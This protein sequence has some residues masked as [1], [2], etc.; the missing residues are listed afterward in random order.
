M[1]GQGP[2]HTEIGALSMFAPTTNANQQ[3]HGDELLGGLAG[4]TSSL[5]IT[6]QISST[7]V[8]ASQKASKLLKNLTNELRKVFDKHAVKG[9]KPGLTLNGRL[10]SSMNLFWGDQS[11]LLNHLSQIVTRVSAVDMGAAAR[12]LDSVLGAL[13]VSNT[14]ILAIIP[15]I[16][17]EAS[18]DT[19]DTLP[20]VIPALASAMDKHINQCDNCDASNLSIAFDNIVS[21]GCV[22]I[23]L[24]IAVEEYV[25]SIEVQKV[26]DQI[27]SISCLAAQHLKLSLCLISHKFQGVHYQVQVPCL[28][29]EVQSSPSFEPPSQNT[30]GGQSA[31]KLPWD[32]TTLF[33]AGDY[34]FSSSMTVSSQI[35]QATEV[36][37]YGA[38]KI[39][40]NAQQATL[41]SQYGSREPSSTSMSSSAPSIP[42]YSGKIIQTLHCNI[43]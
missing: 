17:S 42:E 22:V 29:M 27:A 37:S 4:T 25:T 24:L 13:P 20:F 30:N 15:R 41:P 36:P 10:A 43:D 32:V 5:Q 38:S 40:G 11:P 31:S 35:L 23:S 1:L 12:L 14:D 28:V 19:S 34:T 26:L 39:G 21:Q 9:N 33:P 7:S 2:S 16:A 8:A 3:K 18:V 6:S